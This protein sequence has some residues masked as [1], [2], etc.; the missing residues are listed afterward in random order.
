MPEVSPSWRHN[1]WV[2]HSTP[3]TRSEKSLDIERLQVLLKGTNAWWRNGREQ[4]TGLCGSNEK[5][6]KWIIKCSE[7]QPM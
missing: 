1:A 6:H 5:K 7:E 3:D 2:R 4:E